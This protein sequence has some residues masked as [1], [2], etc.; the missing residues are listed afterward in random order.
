MLLLVPTSTSTSSSDE[1]SWISLE[2]LLVVNGE[3]TGI[4]VSGVAGDLL[5]NISAEIILLFYSFY[6]F[7]FLRFV[8]YLFL[9]SLCPSSF[10]SPLQ[11]LPSPWSPRHSLPHSLPRD[12]CKGKIYL[13]VSL[14]PSF[15]LIVTSSSVLQLLLAILRLVF[16]DHW[17][18][19]R[20]RVG[21]TH[22][23]QPFYLGVLVL[24]S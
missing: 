16:S 24:S 11:L 8:I 6:P 20:K 7:D 14:L 23:G 21:G 1:K 17:P 5:V 15:L 3:E 9:F 18:P 13:F 22:R 19:L 2:T 10:P 4:G 12:L